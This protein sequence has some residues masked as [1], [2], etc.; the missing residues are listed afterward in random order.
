MNAFTNTG[1]RKAIPASA[2]RASAQTPMHSWPSGLPALGEL[3]RKLQSHH[4]VKSSLCTALERIADKL[5]D[6][7][8]MLICRYVAKS[9]TS[10][11][12]RAHEFEENELFPALQAALP[13]NSLLQE[14]LVKLSAEHTEDLSFAEEIED[15]LTTFADDPHRVN[16]ETLGYMLRGFFESLRRHVAFEREM[17]LPLLTSRNAI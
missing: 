3:R 11:V 12:R 16:A 13:G 14:S 1:K 9:I 4:A 15:V 8:D 17:L 10:V 7:A 2:C 6:E 5:P